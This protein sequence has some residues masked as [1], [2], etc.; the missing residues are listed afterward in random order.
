MPRPG[1]RRR[2]ITHAGLLLVF[3]ACAASSGGGLHGEEPAREQLITVP[4]ATGERY[5]LALVN[6]AGRVVGSVLES[7]QPLLEPA[8]SPD[9]SH[10]LYITVDGGLPQ[11]FLKQADAE[12]RKADANLTKSSYLERNPNWSPDGKQICWVRMENNQ[13]VIWTMHAD[14]SGATRISDA[15]I[16]CS[17]PSWSADG[18]TIA[19]STSRQGDRNFRLW[20]VNADGTDARELYK[21]M[22]IRVI[23]PAWSPDGKQI[24]FGGSNGGARVQLCI[25]NADG[26]GFSELAQSEKQCSFAS[27]SPD[28]QYVA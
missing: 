27:W 1:N 11:M 14:G 19:Y 21:Q 28:G 3:M 18:K 20:Q 22:L 4:L 9:G 23:C 7:D 5:Q 2:P 6:L 8:W 15:S 16:M 25:C 10:L 17:N 13:H 24:L 26:E 12:P